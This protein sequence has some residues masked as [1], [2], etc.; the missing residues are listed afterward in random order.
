M[1]C[2]TEIIIDPNSELVRSLNLLYDPNFYE[3]SYDLE[4]DLADIAITI[5]DSH[6]IAF[7][8]EAVSCEMTVWVSDFS[9]I[10]DLTKMLLLT[11]DEM[12]DFA[13]FVSAVSYG[14]MCD[15]YYKAV[16][17]LVSPKLFKNGQGD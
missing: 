17:T 15:E 5:D 12:R 1:I 8:T 7:S 3:V 14:G 13:L 4:D 9:V 10:L 11:K 6:K 2:R 16:L